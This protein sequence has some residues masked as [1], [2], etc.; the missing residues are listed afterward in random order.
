MAGML[1]YGASD[2]LERAVEQGR[3][4]RGA[5]KYT[6]GGGGS[7]YFQIKIPN[8]GIA[9][10]LAIINITSTVGPI[11][12][13]LILDPTITDG[14]TEVDLHNRN[15]YFVDCACG[16]TMFSDPTGISGGT[17]VSEGYIIG[18][19]GTGNLRPGGNF[20]EAVNR[21]LKLDSDYVIKMTNQNAQN[22]AIIGLVIQVENSNQGSW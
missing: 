1:S 2:K 13:Q 10:K 7:A 5:A 11:D 17:V 4:F 9:R 19:T 15:D 6:V 21:V 8:D 20:A 12:L 22:D 16:V 14:T 18:T 3:V